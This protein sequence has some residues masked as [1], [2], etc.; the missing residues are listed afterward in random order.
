M[1]IDFL[2]GLF[3]TIAR[4]QN[5][6]SNWDMNVRS[7]IQIKFRSHNVSTTIHGRF[8]FKETNGTEDN[9]ENICCALITLCELLNKELM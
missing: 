5:T 3:H 4:P 6:V 9:A 7:F 2:N 8:I 1:Y